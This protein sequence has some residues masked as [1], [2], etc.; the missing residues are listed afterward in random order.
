MSTKWVPVGAGDK[1]NQLAGEI[2]DAGS[3]V[4]FVSPHLDDVEP[5]HQSR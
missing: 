2:K 4:M 5:A 1:L 3:P